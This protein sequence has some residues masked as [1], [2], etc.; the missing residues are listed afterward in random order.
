MLSCTYSILW[1]PLRKL[2]TIRASC[3]IELG[4]IASSLALSAPGGVCRPSAFPQIP[5]LHRQNPSAPAAATPPERPSPSVCCHVCP[6]SIAPRNRIRPLS[7]ALGCNSRCGSQPNIIFS[8]SL[9][10]RG[11]R[12][13]VAGRL[14]RVR[15][16]AINGPLVQ[17]CLFAD[18]APHKTWR[19]A[20]YR[21][22]L[23]SVLAGT[24]RTDLAKFEISELMLFKT[25]RY[26]YANW[27]TLHDRADSERALVC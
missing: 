10:D 11:G 18:S 26:V 12:C 5:N 2:A 27:E 9:S 20:S 17:G 14:S 1:R 3:V 16:I 6:V 15:N 7:F 4:R 13:I 21:A 8:Q 19:A 25:C 24:I 22:P 23:I